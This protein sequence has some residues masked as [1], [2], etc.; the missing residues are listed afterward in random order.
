MTKHDATDPFGAP[1]SRRSLLQ[2]GG[3]AGVA[4]LGGTLWATAPAAARARRVRRA[5]TP[6]RHVIISC[7]ENRSFDHYFGYA[8]WAGRYGP[9]PGY[10]Q[11]DGS[12][13]SVKPYRFTQLSTPDIGHS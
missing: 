9:P 13:G 2:R 8:S 10:S 6:I 5:Q 3:A 1:L 11:P 7:Q 4:A 12:G